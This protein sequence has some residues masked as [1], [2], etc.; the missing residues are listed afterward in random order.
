MQEINRI[1]YP[2]QEIGSDIIVTILVSVLLSN[3]ELQGIILHI[4]SNWAPTTTNGRSAPH[5]KVSQLIDITLLSLESRI[6][7]QSTNSVGSS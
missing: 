1:L 7:Y 4:D 2:D 5:I 6:L 3:I